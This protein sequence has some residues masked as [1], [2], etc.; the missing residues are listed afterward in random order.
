MYPEDRGRE[1]N[2]ALKIQG[3]MISNMLHHLNTHKVNSLQGQ[4]NLLHNLTRQW[5]WQAVWSSHIASWNLFLKQLSIFYLLAWIALCCKEIL[6]STE[7]G[8]LSPV[9]SFLSETCQFTSALY[10]LSKF[11]ITILKYFISFLICLDL[12]NRLYG[13]IHQ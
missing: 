1:E 4:N 13:R 5:D 3:E 8:K 9:T 10:L 11:Y 12:I 2:G 6:Q 7:H